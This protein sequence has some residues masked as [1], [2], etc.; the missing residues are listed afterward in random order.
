MRGRTE[1]ALP[2]RHEAVMK[3][4]HAMIRVHDLEAT[5]RFLRRFINR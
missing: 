4:L 1:T 2:F 3:Y 5:G